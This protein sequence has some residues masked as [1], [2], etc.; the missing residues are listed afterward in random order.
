MTRRIMGGTRGRLTVVGDMQTDIAQCPPL[1]PRVMQC[2]AMQA[3][4]VIEYVL[5][6]TV[7]PLL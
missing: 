1:A 2:A 4:A 6:G 7:K 3:D 5:T